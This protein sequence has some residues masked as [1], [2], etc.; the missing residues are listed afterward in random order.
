MKTSPLP[1]LPD[2]S[3]LISRSRSPGANPARQYVSWS[4][5]VMTTDDR[6]L[7]MATVVML[8]LSS[9]NVVSELPLESSSYRRYN[10]L[11]VMVKH[12]SR[13]Y[14]IMLMQCLRR[15]LPPPE[16]KALTRSVV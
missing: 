8:C 13:W 4:R 11:H 10:V 12:A 1:P 7:P 9:T 2:D 16:A 14:R 3:V 6:R 5:V 15:Y